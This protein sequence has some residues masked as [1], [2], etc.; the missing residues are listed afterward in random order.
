MP[1]QPGERI[2]EVVLQRIREGVEQVDTRTLFD[3][4][5]V[6]LFAVPGAFTPTCSEKHLP[7]YVEHFEE[8][9]KRGIEVYCM[10]VND[11]FVMQ[12][13]GKSQLVPDGLQMLSDGNGEFAKALGLEMDASSYGMGVRAR[14]FALYAEHGVVRALFVEAPGEFKVSAADYVLQH[15]PD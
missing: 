15:L 6:L 11:P 2:P 12:A 13:W 8:F 4:H 14:R 7:G 3:D 10:A 1:I 9:R 5:R